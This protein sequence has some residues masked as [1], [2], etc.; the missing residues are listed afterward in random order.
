MTFLLF[1]ASSL[2]LK[3]NLKTFVIAFMV[4]KLRETLVIHTQKGN[5]FSASWQ[6]S[7]HVLCLR[8]ILGAE[9]WMNSQTEA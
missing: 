9:L 8:L 5:P 1:C 3:I 2:Y 7:L 4:M 6:W